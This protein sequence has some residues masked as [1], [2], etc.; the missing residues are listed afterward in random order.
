[1]GGGIRPDYVRCPMTAPDR[2]SGFDTRAILHELGQPLSA[3]LSN[4][5]AAK[6]L[7]A[8]EVP[9]LLEAR[10]ALNDIVT[11]SRQAAKIFRRLETHLLRTGNEPGW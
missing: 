8:S 3:I 1:M 7:L 6:R 10:A 4:A 11:Q 2:S 5:Q 9:D